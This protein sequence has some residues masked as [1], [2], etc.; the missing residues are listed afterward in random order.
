MSE[1]KEITKADYSLFSPRLNLVLDE[2][3]FKRGY[4]RITDFA[5]FFK[6]QKSTARRWL[7][8]NSP[9][10]ATTMETLVDKILVERSEE[11]PNHITKEEILVWLK[12]G[13]NN[14]FATPFDDKQEDK[15]PFEIKCRAYL[16]V[17][18]IAMA[19]GV[20][21]C[22]LSDRKLDELYRQ[23]FNDIETRGLSK[24]DP[25]TI[26]KILNE[27]ENTLF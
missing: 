16:D 24:P 7:V 2:A 10:K 12:A 19:Q 23:I 8:V 17:Y 18:K 5:S 26:S 25:E 15:K 22:A 11:L 20:D 6:V 1:F 3:G 27:T 13:V 21:I 9:P 14:P 4:G